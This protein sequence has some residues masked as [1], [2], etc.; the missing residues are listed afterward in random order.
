LAEPVLAK[1][2]GLACQERVERV[3]PQ[4]VVVVEVF[5]AKSQCPD[6]LTQKLARL[7]FDQA[8]QPIIAKTSV[9]L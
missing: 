1:H 3:E 7:V 9:S 8:W 4:P 5:V 6:T 2:A